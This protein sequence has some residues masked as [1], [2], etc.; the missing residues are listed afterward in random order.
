[1]SPPVDWEMTMVMP[2]GVIAN[3]LIKIEGDL[4]FLSMKA[5]EQSGEEGSRSTKAIDARLELIYGALDSIGA[6]VGR[7]QADIHPKAHNMKTSS[8]KSSAERDD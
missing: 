5:I 8:H 7:L 4:R 2:L 1:M 3:Q 6:L